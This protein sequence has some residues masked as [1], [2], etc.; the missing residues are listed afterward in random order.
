[1]SELGDFLGIVEYIVGYIVCRSKRSNLCPERVEGLH[2]SQ[3]G[4]PPLGPRHFPFV[5]GYFYV[6]LETVPLAYGNSI[7]AEVRFAWE[8]PSDRTR[9][10]TVARFGIAV[11]DLPGRSTKKR[12]IVRPTNISEVSSRAYCSADGGR[13]GADI[14]RL[15]SAFRSEV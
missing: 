9:L 1:M 10:P 2:F 6:L 11:R 5:G 8:I 12:F 4:P 14:V 7:G 15:R 3:L 13:R